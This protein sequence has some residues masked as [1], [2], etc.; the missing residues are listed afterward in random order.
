MREPGVRSRTILL[1]LV[2]GTFLIGDGDAA[3]SS[4]T[5]TEIRSAVERA[6]PLLETASAGT[7]ENRKC[8]TCHGQAMPVIAIVAAGRRG[9]DLDADN[10]K[11]QVDHTHKHLSRGQKSY[12][13]GKGQGGGV[14]T[15]GYALWTLEDGGRER[16]DVVT[17][18]T[19]WLLT[20]Q[21]ENGSWHCSSNRP[22]S[23]ASNLT[24]TYLA[25]RA[26]THFAS[27][28]QSKAVEQATDRAARWLAEAEV[29]DT[30]DQVFRLLAFSYGEIPNSLTAAAVD[31]LK[32]EQRDDGGWSQTP[33]MDSDAYATATA[34][35]ALR[36]AGGIE[37]VDQVWN[38]GISFL[39]KHQHED[40]SWLVQSRSKPF[41]NYFESGFPHGKDQFI[42]TSATAWAT[43]VLVESLPEK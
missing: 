8:F 37:N 24:T 29:Q 25:L 15:A 20:K 4:P 43:I 32:R 17:A 40:G 21:G 36:Q 18:V 38:R 27:D 30:E 5:E 22:P 33:G 6:L 12:L 19:D 31:R 14:D 7:A 28:Q 9:F 10:L 26:L 42:S 11:R 41:Q 35:Y 2:C 39:L 23:E 1:S 3:E 16:D 34:L 13:Q